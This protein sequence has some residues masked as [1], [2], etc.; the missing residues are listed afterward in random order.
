MRRGTTPKHIFT[1]D[2]DLT[3]AEVIYITYKQGGQVVAEKELADFNEVSPE[4]IAV[5]LTQ[6]ETL[7]FSEYSEVYIQIR[8]RFADGHAVAS[9]IMKV[10]A[11]AILKEGVI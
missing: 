7:A 11:E 9:N 2:V 1:T 10:P 4:E 3:D 8:A 6:E 5:E